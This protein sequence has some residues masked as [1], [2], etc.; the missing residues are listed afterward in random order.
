MPVTTELWAEFGTSP[1]L[2]GATH[3]LQTGALCAMLGHPVPA[4]TA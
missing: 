4:Q 3:T 1:S 2:Y